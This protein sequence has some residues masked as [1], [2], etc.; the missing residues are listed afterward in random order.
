V[1]IPEP[2][3]NDKSLKHNYPNEGGVAGDIRFL[4]NIMG[5][6]LVQECRRQWVKEGKEYSYAEL[7]RLAG[8]ARPFVAVVDPDHKPFLSPGEMPGKIVEFCRKTGQAAPAT[9]GE[10]VRTCLESLALT[11][12]KTIEGLED[13]LGRRIGVIH[14]VGGGTQNELLNQMT[15]DA[16]DRPVVAGPVEATAIGNML[17]T[18][19]ALGEIKDLAEGRRIVRES[20]EVKG[21]E[22]RDSGRWGE[23]YGRYKRTS[24]NMKS[25][26]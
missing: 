25:E 1:V 16:C 24:E 21:Y 13:V 11:Y 15:A 8:E 10:F 20:F 17:V 12:R 9:P 5:L 6:W 4:K 23:A 7:T 14:I 22:P 26:T 3:I 18:A 19:I 2:I